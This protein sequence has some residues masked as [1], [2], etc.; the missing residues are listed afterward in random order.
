MMDLGHFRGPA[1]HD[2]DAGPA[3]P[4]FELFDPNRHAV[5]RG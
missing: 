3:R 1:A 2:L 5:T 4:D